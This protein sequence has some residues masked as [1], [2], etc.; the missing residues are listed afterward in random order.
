MPKIKFEEQL[1]KTLQ[2][3]G[4]DLLISQERSTKLKWTENSSYSL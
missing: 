3:E 1:T 2:T 4:S